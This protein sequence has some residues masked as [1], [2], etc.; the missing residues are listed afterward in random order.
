MDP[1]NSWREEKQSAWLYRALAAAEPDTRIAALFRTLADAAESQAQTWAAAAQEAGE[2]LPEPFVPE[3]RARLVAGLARRLG[4]RR[5]KPALAALKVRGLSAYTAALTGHLLPTDL[6]QVGVS[7]R[8]VGGGNLRAAIFGVNDGLV[9]NAS[10]I[11]GVVGASAS[12]G[13]VL[14]TGIAGLLAGALSMAAGEYVSVRSQRELFEYQ[15]GLESD[16]LKKYPEAEAEE[17]ALIYIARGMPAEQ[18]R[19]F[20]ATLVKDPAQALD[21]LAREELGL[22]PDDLG[23]PI[24][25]A[26]FSFSAFTIGALIP[27]V[28]FFAGSALPQ[29]AF[30]GTGLAAAGLFGT[31]A[32]MSLFT[33]RNPWAGGAR[34]LGIGALAGATVFAIGRLIGVDVA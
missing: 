2:I 24:G 20:A 14:A 10:L 11:L 32:A 1:G 5:M 19:G 31:G 34:M 30:W 33:G 6:A 26:A 4:P 21:V 7:H 8:S 13:T 17:L 15:I 16:E 3:R 23:S 9:S 12:T 27:L 29:A 22:N 25:A 18:A 28:P